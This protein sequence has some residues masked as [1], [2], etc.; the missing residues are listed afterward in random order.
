MP[1]E[2]DIFLIIS[3]QLINY[4]ASWC[5]KIQYPDLKSDTLTVNPGSQLLTPSGSIGRPWLAER[6]NIFMLL[7]AAASAAT[8]IT[9]P[10]RIQTAREDLRH[11]RG[12]V[13]CPER[14]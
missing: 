5:F 10:S 6:W 8:T 4:N 7:L 9:I 2:I 3:K 11:G 13:L 12:P 14:V 1:V